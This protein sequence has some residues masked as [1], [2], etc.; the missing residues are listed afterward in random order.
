M[1]YYSL[2][3]RDAYFTNNKYDTFKGIACIDYFHV[4]KRRV[5]E[6][7][8]EIVIKVQQDGLAKSNKVDAVQLTVRWIESLMSYRFKLKRYR[9]KT[10]KI[11]NTIIGC[12]HFI[13]Q[14]P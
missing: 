7:E 3:F 6:S 1:A 8:L 2:S 12:L 10:N 4:L 13:I 5:N 14:P 11:I 9:N